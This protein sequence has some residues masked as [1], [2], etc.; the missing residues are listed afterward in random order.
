LGRRPAIGAALKLTGLIRLTPIAAAG[1]R[2]AYV[3][4]SVEWD[5]IG[6][7]FTNPIQGF[8][9]VYGWNAV[10]PL[11]TS[12]ISDLALLLEAFGL[13]IDYFLV[14]DDLATFVNAGSPPADPPLLVNCEIASLFDV[15]DGV[16]AGV[17]LLLRPPTASRGFAFA[18]LPYARLQGATSIPLTD[19]FALTIGGNADFLKGVAI[20]F[21]PGS[22]PQA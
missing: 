6:R 19:T 8:Q 10:T 7:L 20:T 14:E 22:D 18:I 21:A 9:E 16:S 2:A 4:R 11:L 1:L 15:P 5:E 3:K 17:Q 13:D 12:A